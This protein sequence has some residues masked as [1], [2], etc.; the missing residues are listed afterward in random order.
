MCSLYIHILQ[1]INHITM[2]LCT[3]QLKQI[4][5]FVSIIFI[6]IHRRRLVSEPFLLCFCSDVL[7][8]KLTDVSIHLRGPA[9]FLTTMIEHISRTAIRTLIQIFRFLSLTFS[10]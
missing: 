2:Y 5:K 6:I 8:A 10:V 4:P 7:E 1:K 9:S 3:L